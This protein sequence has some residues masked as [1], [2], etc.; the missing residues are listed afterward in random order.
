MRLMSRCGG[1]PNRR[2]LF[3][4]GGIGASLDFVTAYAAPTF[5]LEGSMEE[6]A[7]PG[8]RWPRDRPRQPSA[9]PRTASIACR[10]RCPSAER[11]LR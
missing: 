8:T 11:S 2:L 10:S 9:Q 6:R 3:E 1:A 4:W 7:R 5:G